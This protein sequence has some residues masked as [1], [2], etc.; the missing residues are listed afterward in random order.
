MKNKITVTGANIT[1]F[2]F[3]MLYIMFSIGT[4]FFALLFGE[5]SITEGFIPITLITQFLVVLGPAFLYMII[6]NLNFKEVLRLNNPGLAPMV[7]ILLS[8][9][10][11]NIVGTAL[12]ML[13]VYPLSL[14][15]ELP[16]QPIPVPENIFE[17]VI[18]IL[19]IA[20]TPGICEEILN[21]GIILKAYEKRGSYKAMVICGMFFGIFHFD[22]QNLLGPIFLGIFFSYYVIRTNSIFTGMFAHFLNNAF[23]V[24]ILYLSRGEG[25]EESTKITFEQFGLAMLEGMI[26]FALLVVLLLIFTKI[27]DNKYRLVPPISNAGRDFVSII[28]HWPI[29]VTLCL[30][31]M[32]NGLIFLTI[33][34]SNFV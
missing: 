31:I 29:I 1:F 8:V 15:G 24:I 30:Y 21:R 9:I 3:T 6:A 23:A 13:I 16:K 5:K 22:M 28:S 18:M 33:V 10:P 32:I 7:I 34:G 2:S 12:N 27:T 19:V 20:V 4:G 14:I 11:A 25:I 17:V 26:A